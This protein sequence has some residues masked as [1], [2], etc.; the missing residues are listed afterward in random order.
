MVQVING[1]E[2][3]V[4]LRVL[5][6]GYWVLSARAF[7]RGEGH[8][9]ERQER[10]QRDDLDRRLARFPGWEVISVDT[11]SARDE[12]VKLGVTQ[13]CIDRF[14]VRERKHELVIAGERHSPNLAIPWVALPCADQ[15]RFACGALGRAECKHDDDEQNARA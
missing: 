10:K 12:E 4:R 15:F 8:S 3:D 6:I 9:A 13:I 11:P 2:E 5:R 14:I 1:D 7:G